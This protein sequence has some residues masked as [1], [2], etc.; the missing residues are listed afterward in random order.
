MFLWFSVWA[1]PFKRLIRGRGFRT[2][3]AQGAQRGG[4]SAARRLAGDH[5]PWA[6]QGRMG[7]VKGKIWDE[8]W[9]LCG[10]QSSGHEWDFMMF[11]DM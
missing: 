10:S 5:V 6:R 1:T 2:G 11:N 9:D 4:R 8:K 3:G 7:K